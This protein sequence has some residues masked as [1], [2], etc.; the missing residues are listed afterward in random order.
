MELHHS[1]HHQAYVTGYNTSFEK[2]QEVGH[3][4]GQA[5]AEACGYIVN[6]K[7]SHLVKQQ[8]NH[9]EKKDLACRLK[10]RRMWPK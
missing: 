2:F 5:S 7:C 4:C 8:K 3:S 6:M 9:R 10:Q 1:K